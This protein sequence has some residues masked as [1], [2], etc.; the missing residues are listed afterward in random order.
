VPT[1]PDPLPI[2]VISAGAGSGKTYALTQKM[3]QLLQSGVRPSGIMATT[4]TQKAAAELQERVRAR[5]L[6]L[7]MFEAANELGSAL[8]GTVHSIGA[9]LLQRFAFEAGVSPLV[10]IIA[11]SDA[12][13]LFNESLAQVLSLARIEQ[14]NRLADRLGLTKKTLGEPFDWRRVIRE[15]TDV[16]RANNFSRHTLEISKQRSWESF[17]R[18]L[19]PAQTTAPLQ[20]H[21]R[22]LSLLDQT[23]AALDAHEADSTKTTR[24]AAEHLRSVQN[25]LKWR[26]EL[27]WHEWVKI[28]KTNV[29]AKSRDLFQDLRDFALSHDEHRQLHED[30]RAF[31]E[32][33][34]D[35]SMDA[36]EEFEQYK[37][38][39][40]LID[41]TDMETYVSRLLRLEPVR[42][43]LRR[44]IDLLLVDEFQ[45]TSPIQ[46]D[47]FLQI[48]R[49]TRHSIWVGDPKQSI[50]GFRGAE[51]ALMQAIINATGGVRDENILKRSWRS[52]PTLVHAVNAIFTR[53]FPQM[54]PEQIVLDPARH[55][56]PGGLHH[57]HFRSDLDARKAPGKP[58]LEN[59]I[60]QQ[61]KTT[62]EREWPSFDKNGQPARPLQ[63]G[64]IAV[65][66]RTNG[67][68]LEMAE[69]LHRA[70]LK[71][72][73]ARNG[74]LDTPEAR[75]TLA[76]MKYL[77]TATDTLSMTEMVLITGGQHLNDLIEDRLGFLEQ[78]ADTQR[79]R[80]VLDDPFVAQVNALRP[81]AADLSASE[82]LQLVLDELDLRRVV[83]AFG[84]PEQRLDNLDRLRY[85]ALEYESACNRLHSAATLGGFL[86]WLQALADQERDAQGAAESPDAVKI[87]TYHRSKGL[88][89]PLTVCHGLD[90]NLKE[91]IWGINLVSENDT[92]DLDNIL[93][94]RWLRY[95]VNPYA[96]QFRGTRLEDQLQ[97]SPEW[98]AATR[99]ALDEEARLL[100]VGLTRARD[101]LVI[102]SSVRGTKWLNRVFSHGD[103]D[104]PTFDPDTDES[105]LYFNDQVVPLETEIVYAGREFP[106]AL[107]DLQP[108][109]FHAPRRG[110][111]PGNRQSLYIHA[112]E[113]M[114]PGAEPDFQEPNSFAPWVAFQE[115][116]DPGIA[117]ALRS[118]MMAVRIAG[119]EPWADLAD[120]QV[121]I[122]YLQQKVPAEALIHQTRQF[123]NWCWRHL[124]PA[125][126]QA[127]YPME[128]VLGKRRIQLEADLFW[129]NA[130]QAG[131][132]AFAP[133]AEGAKK[134]KTQAQQLAPGLLWGRRV[135]EQYFPG[136]TIRCCIVFPVEGLWVEL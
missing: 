69:A 19:P 57:W 120:F 105:P 1:Q 9:R 59:C 23:A 86:I 41:Y 16:A 77:L 101:Y 115:E 27:Y 71:A 118:M 114:P 74:L 55:S 10:E 7:G 93:G 136:K 90:T 38:K 46:L 73:I 42:E 111:H 45:D 58:W 70:G 129:E 39:R 121:R 117:A 64:D 72:S 37:K 80:W 65:L 40:G 99:T 5:L 91:Q 63:A 61:I 20:W 48:S 122:R 131:L 116:Y 13:R 78:A 36:L 52:R 123:R 130:T 30:I 54:P 83:V 60:A 68:C 67:A 66:C 31:I 127:P 135:L 76:C 96:D 18:F 12:Q 8:I 15:L 22:L 104:I 4:F 98:A 85:Y 112:G 87:L 28:A 49:L 14:M 124:A 21:N 6:E 128:A 97:Q 133:F 103:E 106:E 26:E 107:P 32:L 2:T 33:V 100:Y 110:K 53:A 62:L 44:E 29:G 113:E 35:I 132:I 3:V 84:N 134:W 108:V 43:V 82:I 102:P 51:P 24:D 25:Q 81:R 17:Q 47:I 56:T 89:Y 109:P 94:G 92:P 119:G 50:Y 79:A 75:L 11:E 125:R 34:F 88:E 126:V 95:W